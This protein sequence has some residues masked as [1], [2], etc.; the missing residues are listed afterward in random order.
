MSTTQQ[1]S[2]HQIAQRDQIKREY[3]HDP[4]TGRI[5]SPGKF[6][7]EPI[8]APYYW[9]MGLEGF[10]DSDNGNAYGFRF[11]ANDPDFALWPEL[12]Q[13]LGRKRTMKL[14]E[15]DTGFVFCR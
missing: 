13:W 10:S 7:S 9:Q 5:T 1:P 15:S 14:I 4:V 6:E 8:F 11:K 2:E 12:K 3:A